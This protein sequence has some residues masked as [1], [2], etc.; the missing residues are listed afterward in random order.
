MVT[1]IDNYPNEQAM[2]AAKNRGGFRH[3]QGWRPLHTNNNL[4]GTWTIHWNNDPSPPPPPKRNLTQ[5]QFLDELAD[6][7]NINII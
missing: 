7:R 2:K 4:D 5:S 3:A 1:E 6:E